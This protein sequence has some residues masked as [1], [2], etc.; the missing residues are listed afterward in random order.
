[1]DTLFKIVF[2][3]SLDGSSRV[4]QLEAMVELK[5]SAPHYKVNRISR[6]GQNN[7]SD[8]L[9][10]VDIK[11]ILTSDGQYKWVHTD[12]GKET[13]LS[14]VIGAAIEKTQGNPKIADDNDD[15]EEE[16]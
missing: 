8:L 16:I 7:P 6:R 14:N 3:F 13:Y 4:L 9:P 11:C 2:D 12:S 1:M 10:E 5:Y 15:P